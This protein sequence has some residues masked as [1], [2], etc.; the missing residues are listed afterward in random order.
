VKP[1]DTE[2]A[3]RVGDGAAELQ[4][5]AEVVA[6]V[7]TSEWQHRERIAAYLPGAG[8]VLPGYRRMRAPRWSCGERHPW[9]G[10]EGWGYPEKAM[11]IQR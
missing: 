2:N 9:S 5:V 1:V 8:S 3:R 6:H 10:G 7:V 4:P 11:N